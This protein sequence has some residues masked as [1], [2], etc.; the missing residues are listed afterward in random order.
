MFPSEARI[1]LIRSDSALE[2]ERIPIRTPP[3]TPDLTRPD[4]TR[5]DPSSYLAF[6]CDPPAFSEVTTDR[7]RGSRRKAMDST[8]QWIRRRTM[9]DHQQ[10]ARQAARAELRGRNE[11][12]EG[13]MA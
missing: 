2:S 8:G 5:P 10:A 1:R 11:T 12:P 7:A 6:S 4:Q 9:T 3:W 13:E